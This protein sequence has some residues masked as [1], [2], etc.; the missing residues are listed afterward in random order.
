MGLTILLP[1]LIH[2]CFTV[3]YTAGTLAARVAQAVSRVTCV[4]ALNVAVNWWTEW[5][6]RTAFLRA[7]ALGE[8]ERFMAE[9][10]PHTSSTQR[11]AD[12]V[13]LGPVGNDAATSIPSVVA[14]QP[15]GVRH[16]WSTGMHWL[17]CRLVAWGLLFDSSEMEY[18]CAVVVVVGR[19]CAASAMHALCEDVCTAHAPPSLQL[20]DALDVVLSGICCGAPQVPTAH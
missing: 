19:R 9:I 5:R 3:Y 20:C 1:A 11:R 8:T 10:P 6:T 18:R 15:S 12:S 16:M 4:A 17:K 7:S 2:Q 13:Q 14:V